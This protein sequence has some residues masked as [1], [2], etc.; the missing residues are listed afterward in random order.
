[1]KVLV[2][3]ANGQVARALAKSAPQGW[4]CVAL[5]KTTCDL[6]SETSILSAVAS[7][8]PDLVI[9]AAAYTAVDRAERDEVLATTVNAT[10]VGILKKALDRHGGRLV[11]ISSD[12][13][14]DGTSTAPYP[15]S[16]PRTPVSAYGRSKAA[17]EILAGPDA[18]VVRTSWVYGAGGHNFVRSMLRLMRER[19]E[20]R[21][22]A[23]QIGAP[24]WASG[25]AAAL[26][27]LAAN[28]CKGIMHYRDAGVAS[29][30]DFAVAIQ[31]E[32]LAIGL[33]NR[34]VPIVPIATSEYPTAAYRPAVA[35]LDDTKTWEALGARPSHW[36]VNLRRMLKEEMAL[37]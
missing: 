7:H 21:V 2:T 16:A 33:L 15:P 23:D 8:Q 26:W 5:C 19:D 1:M 37:G 34:A 12:Y 6:L 24:T 25:L 32:A 14:F 4:D 11:H 29:W 9:N 3:G 35:I 36:R 22:V 13:V 17:G 27:A 30:Y 28:G 10:A 18:L 31:E 20:V